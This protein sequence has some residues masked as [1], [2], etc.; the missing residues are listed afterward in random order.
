[1][2]SLRN[3]LLRY[4]H[5]GG[6]DYAAIAQ[7]QKKIKVNQASAARARVSLKSENVFSC[8]SR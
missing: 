3:K 8:L 1:M 4:S 6:I 2:N 5:E 7:Y